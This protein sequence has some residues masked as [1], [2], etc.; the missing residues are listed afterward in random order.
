[1]AIVYKPR[2]IY[3]ED[4]YGDSFSPSY[5]HQVSSSY[6]TYGSFSSYDNLDYYY[7][8]AT[9]GNYKLT[10]TTEG[11]SNVYNNNFTV[12]II[13]SF[14]NTILTEDAFRSDVYTDNITFY[15]YQS[16]LSS[17]SSSSPSPITPRPTRQTVYAP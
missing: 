1:M 10:L 2:N 9:A 17:S 7:I 3:S 6:L 14:G 13:D 4:A 15:Y 5:L 8:N 12:I 16:I 11:L